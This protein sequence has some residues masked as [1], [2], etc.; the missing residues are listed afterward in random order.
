M[1]I[2]GLKYL[3]PLKSNKK[4]IQFQT[5]DI[6]VSPLIEN[7]IVITKT[8]FFHKDSTLGNLIDEINDIYPPKNIDSDNKK[9]NDNSLNLQTI[10]NEKENEKYTPLRNTV[11]VLDERI[12]SSTTTEAFIDEPTSEIHR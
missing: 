11:S 5:D 8:R 10:T 3:F 9:N 6:S 4:G 7:S 12:L 1:K 2:W